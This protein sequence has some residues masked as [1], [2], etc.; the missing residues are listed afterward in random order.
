VYSITQRDSFEELGQWIQK[1]KDSGADFI[2]VGNKTDLESERDV[3]FEEAD[4]FARDQG[5]LCYLEVSA[6][7]GDNVQLILDS[8]PAAMP[9]APSVETLPGPFSAENEAPSCC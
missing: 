2:L 4:Q 6:R 1:A 9:I 3:D 7:T 8:I 5:A